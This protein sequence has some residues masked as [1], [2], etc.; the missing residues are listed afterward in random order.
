V[1]ASDKVRQLTQRFS[2]F[3]AP[4]REAEMLVTGALDMTRAALYS[5]DLEISKEDSDRIDSFADRRVKGEPM[6]YIIGYVEFLGLR[7]E[8]GKGVLIP[9]PETE[10]LVEEALKQISATIS[11]R[12]SA[13]SNKESSGG[14]SQGAAP[15]EPVITVLD[16][17][18]GSGCIAIALDKALSKSA[19]CGIDSSEAALS[20]AVR[21][22]EINNVSNVIFIKGDLFAPLEKGPEFDLVISNPP[23]IRCGAMDKLQIEIRDHEPGEALDGGEDGLDFYRRIFADAP[24]FMKDPGLLMLEIGAGQADDIRTLAVDAALKDIQFIKDYS[25]IERIFIGRR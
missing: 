12:Q 13:V 5:K 20:Y 14:G 9:R 6:S 19:V 10:L 25:G 11:S 22:A 4:L 17:C 21:N 8:V 18:T 2:A 1:T 7:I 15:Q 23:Y 3:E 16:L 24:D